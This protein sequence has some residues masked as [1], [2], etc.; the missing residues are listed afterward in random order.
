MPLF[1]R[2]RSHLILHNQRLLHVD[3]PEHYLRQTGAT[4]Q[5]K[6]GK[7]KILY[8][9]LSIA[10]QLVPHIATMNGRRGGSKQT[11]DRDSADM[12]MML[13]CLEALVQ[14]MKPKTG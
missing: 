11:R 8:L 10:P 9:V 5:F 3:F 2:A 12:L 6:A 1:S 14:Y 13:R 4:D 7:C